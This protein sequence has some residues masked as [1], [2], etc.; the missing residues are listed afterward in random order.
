MLHL[1]M[2]KQDGDRVKEG[3]VYSN[4]G[5]AYYSIGAFRKAVEYHQL[6]L[7]ISKE[8][9]ERE[10]EGR[11]Y[12]NLGIACISLGDFRKAIEY[13][14]LQHTIFKELGDRSGQMRACANLGAAYHSLGD[15]KKAIEYHQIHLEIAK[16]VGNRSAEGRGYANLGIDSL[17][18][19]DFKK[20]IEYHSLDLSIANET[21]DKAGQG[22]A[23]CNIGNT[24]C[25]SGEFMKAM[26]YHQP[27][28]G[29]AKELG[30]RVA[31]A[32]AYSNLGIVYKSLGDFKTAIEYH[33]Q[34][35]SFTKETGDKA[36]EGCAYA[37]LGIVYDCMSDFNEAIKYHQLHLDIAKKV[38]DRHGEECAYGNL[39]IAYRSLGDFQKAIECHQ[40][41]LTMAKDVEN[42]PGEGRSYAN[43]GICYHYLGE[44]TKAREYHQLQLTVAKDLGDRAGEGRAYSNLG[45]TLTSL[46]DF[47]TA[48]EYHQLSLNIA[49]Q[50]G[51]R[52]QEGRVYANLGDAYRSLRDLSK[53][54][55]CYKS[56][57]R[58]LESISDRLQKNDEWK[59][60]LRNHYKNPYTAL[61]N[62]LLLQNKTGEAL[63]AAEQGRAQALMDLMESHY[64]LKLKQPGSGEQMETFDD[65]LNYITSEIVFLAVGPN[66]VNFWVLHGDSKKCEFVKKI[67]RN[68]KYLEESARN[69]LESLNEAAYSQI[70]VIKSV[71]C[72]PYDPFKVFYDLVVSPVANLIRGNE[73]TIVPDGPL[74]LAPFAA[75]MDQNSN[76]LSDTFKIRLIPT[77][78][79]LK[80]LAESSQQSHSTTGALLVGDP[81]L[82]NV[83]IKGKTP[84]QLSNAIKEVEMI[85]EILKIKPLTGKGAT[86]AEVLKKLSSVALVHI[87]AHGKEATGEI[88]LSPNPTQSKRPKERDYLL[89]MEDVKNANLNARLVVL[90]CC[91]SSQGE[92]K[93]EGVVGI[94]RAFLGAGARSVL[95]SLWKIDD[96][97]TLKFMEI[98]YKQLLQEKQS[99]SKSLNQAMKQMQESDDFSDVRLWAPFVPIGD[100]VTFDFHQ[101]R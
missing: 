92:V 47:K 80:I 5:Q 39:G 27:D 63:L 35:L 67:I 101:T 100:D 2:A 46:G 91:H 78:S 56:S 75:F 22:R 57:V 7:T 10:G 73:V 76:Y 64:G 60:S 9:G 69:T 29:I 86:K 19:G 42:K 51:D 71:E 31:E 25:S 88:L 6:H 53:A 30:D 43:L 90:S 16:E 38:E 93:A 28:L 83:R 1:S 62:V 48:I 14:D 49:K 45:I 95:A 13:H 44:F 18:L 70:G 98:F 79:T 82:G 23:Y 37:N 15:F 58:I 61:W 77:L 41:S 3:Y 54:E 81:W 12:G 21:K 99:A 36:G 4:L 50:D 85:G 66:A 52:P 24:Y 55:Q 94:A 59:I 72:P 74:F 11:A 20:A 32:K 68:E 96:A 84:D 26:E 87:A 8:V 40:G 17:S 97:A 33:Q 65:I 34:Y 89:T